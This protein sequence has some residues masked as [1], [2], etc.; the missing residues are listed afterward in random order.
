MRRKEDSDAA[1]ADEAAI[2]QTQEQVLNWSGLPPGTQAPSYIP[3]ALK[4]FWAAGTALSTLVGNAPEILQGYSQ[5]KGIIYPGSNYIGPFNP[6]EEQGSAP[7][8]SQMDDLA[9]IHDYQYGQ[10]MEQGV[11]PYFTFNEADRYMLSQVNL[12]TAE[13][14]AIYL[15]IGLK[16]IFPD[17][18]TKI[19]PVPTYG[20][21]GD[22]PPQLYP[23]AQRMWENRQIWKSEMYE[24]MAI[25]N[26]DLQQNLQTQQEKSPF[27]RSLLGA[28]GGG[29]GAGAA[30]PTP[31]PRDFGKDPFLRRFFLG[32]SSS[33]MAAGGPNAT[34]RLAL[35]A[36]LRSPSSALRFLSTGHSSRSLSSAHNNVA[37]IASRQNKPTINLMHPAVQRDYK[38]NSYSLGNSSQFSQ[39]SR[40]G[41]FV[42][43]FVKR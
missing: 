22:N 23:N 29:A 28:V 15:G 32:A 11:N 38:N 2:T 10:L 33:E 26:Q 4:Q 40:N 14:W 37:T 25:A 41:L 36:G 19:N 20:G 43:S 12:S 34:A 9:R 13:G 39:F 31:Q 5:G 8:T 35:S 1:A 17:D 7:P 42:P 3:E 16:Q 30:T 24:K 21:A 18:Y 27:I 6:L